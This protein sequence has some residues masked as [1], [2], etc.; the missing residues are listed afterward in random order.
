M[1][2][3]PVEDDTY[4]FDPA[5][6]DQP[7][8][9]IETYCRHT[10]GRTFA[11]APFVLLPWQRQLVRTI[12]GWKERATGLR[13]FREVYLLS[14]K[15]AG[16]TPLL[17]AVGLY[18]LLAD[19]EGDPHVISMASTSEQARLTFDQAK[20]YVE[21]DPKL[22]A[23]AQCK[24]HVIR[25]PKGRRGKW[26]P[27]SGKNTGKSGTRPSCIIADE[28]HEW[29][30]EAAAAYEMLT[31]NAFKRSQ[32]LILN[33]TNAG[34]SRTSF[35]FRQHD[36]ARR[37]L[38]GELV[39]PTLLPVIFEAP[40]ALPWDSE[41][42]AAAANPSLGSIVSFG[43][44]APEVAKAR[45]GAAEEA[46]YRRL[47]L[48]QWPAAR[49]GGWLN[50]DQ[51]DKAC[52]PFNASDLTAYPLYVGIDGSAGDD[53]F[54]AAFVW[55]T[56]GRMFATAHFW[57]PKATAERYEARQ[58]TPFAAW[59]TAGW[60]TLLD[61]PSIGPAEQRAIA[62]RVLAMSKVHRVKVVGYDRSYTSV[63]VAELSA[64]GLNVMPK[65]Q[66][67]GISAGAKELVDRLAAADGS[68]RIAPSPVLRWNAENAEKGQDR[69]G[70]VWPVKPNAAGRYAGIR[71][72]KIDGVTA[73]VTALTDARTEEFPATDHHRGTACLA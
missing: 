11:G 25:V 37:V 57:L 51:W 3:E 32:P 16:K 40:A 62:A 36:R 55:A 9:V 29:S 34:D 70:N 64:A 39:A 54:A 23:R 68:I 27:S 17:A 10:E 31:A 26:T 73:L 18:M 63:T 2:L 12:F 28:L 46:K 7:C 43:Q 48:S 41:A 49:T 20:K 61:A 4:T 67:W 1:M 14:A 65:G 30:G 53:L 19:G 5:A 38:A 15:G 60:I 35:A 71:H 42:A 47:Y 69:Q 8:R 44:L 21:A 45:A 52:G 56:R 22:S 72:A 24:Q 13:R 66:G 59:A 33:A 58:G 6:A 50:M